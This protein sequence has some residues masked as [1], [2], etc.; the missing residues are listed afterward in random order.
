MERLSYFLASSPC[1]LANPP[2]QS[3]VSVSCSLFPSCFL[4]FLTTIQTPP[5]LEA[6]LV[7]KF[8]HEAISN[9]S[10]PLSKL[11]TVLWID[12]RSARM[13]LFCNHLW[14]SRGQGLWPSHPTHIM[15]G[16]QKTLKKCW[17]DGNCVGNRGTLLR[18][19]FRITWW[20]AN[21]L[22]ASRGC[23]FRSSLEVLLRLCF[24]WFLQVRDCAWWGY[25]NRA[26]SGWCCMP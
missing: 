23:A 25:Q 17:L 19:S 7:A 18:W 1:L 26:V 16:I 5:S 9:T 20:R 13:T 8:S 6:Q 15:P 2:H 14:F 21:C 22:R 24:P 12:N 11:G 4:S 3:L 10:P